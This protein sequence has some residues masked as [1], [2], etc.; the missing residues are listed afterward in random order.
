MADFT[1]KSEPVVRPFFTRTFFAMMVFSAALVSVNSGPA[2]A[3]A[4]GP[5]S[6]PELKRLVIGKGHSVRQNV[7]GTLILLSILKKEKERKDLHHAWCEN[8][9]R[10]YL[11]KSETFQP[12]NGP[13]RKCISPH[14]RKSRRR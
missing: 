3:E 13:R 4:V 2:S 10:S 14:T 5:G 1:Q 8:R 7:V 12:Y 6:A 9:Y 11:R